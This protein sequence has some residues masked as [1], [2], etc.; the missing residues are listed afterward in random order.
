MKTID[1]PTFDAALGSA[2]TQDGQSLAQ[3]SRSAPTLV[4]FLRHLGCAFCRE[5]LAD[6]ARARPELEA[7]GTAVVLVHQSS[8]EEAEPFF[9]GYGLDDVARISDPGL[10]LYRAFGLRRGQLSQ[11]LAPTVVARAGAALLRGHGPGRP[12][13]DTRQMPGV[14]LLRDGE[15]V[16]SF[17]HETA[18]DRPDYAGIARCD[19]GVCDVAA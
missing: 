10:G 3:L 9:A 12:Q 4:V 13:G 18:A 14:F 5:A 6:V 11:L 8:E 2:V 17:R 1:V 19:G 7:A 16:A 15:I